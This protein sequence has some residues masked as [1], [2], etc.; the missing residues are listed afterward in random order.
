MRRLLSLVVLSTILGV[1]AGVTSTA[2]AAQAPQFT[3][4]TVVSQPSFEAPLAPLVIAFTESKIKKRI[5]PEVTLAG[6]GEVIW[7]C[8]FT[9]TTPNSYLGPIPASYVDISFE[10][11]KREV[12][13]TVTVTA[14]L[15]IPSEC[16]EA[17]QNPGI[18]P[19]LLANIYGA[20]APQVDPALVGPLTL[21][22]TATGAS[23]TLP[24]SYGFC[25]AHYGYC[26]R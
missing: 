17:A 16:P 4:V 12:T 6:L 10:R 24:S 2:F 14:P 18:V 5:A 26:I 25:S 8:S 3:S 19:E 11:A 15:P 9:G 13:G 7:D 22:D 21:T 20:P 1:G 23:Y